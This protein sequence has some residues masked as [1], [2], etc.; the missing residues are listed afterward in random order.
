MLVAFFGIVCAVCG[1]ILGWNEGKHTL[2]GKL[3]DDDKISVDTFKKEMN[4]LL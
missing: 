2:L 3:A 4:K 1:F